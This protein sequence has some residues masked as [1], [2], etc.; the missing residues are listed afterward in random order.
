MVAYHRHVYP[1]RRRYTSQW[2]NVNSR[3]DV[4]VRWR[5]AMRPTPPASRVPSE[6]PA[7]SLTKKEIPGDDLLSHPVARAVPSAL[8][9]LT[10]VFG[11]GTGVSP[12]LWSPDTSLSKVGDR[13]SGG[14]AIGFPA[15]GC[16]AAAGSL[17]CVEIRRIANHE[18]RF[19]PIIRTSSGIER[20]SPRPISTAQLKE[21]PLLHLRPINQLVSLGSYPVD[22]V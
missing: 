2:H 12:P 4:R 19:S 20:S 17:V 18:S 13:I 5:P 9:G 8:A 7:L 1:H 3:R 16:R 21:L 11:M 10:A 22:P 15:R 14:C 6:P